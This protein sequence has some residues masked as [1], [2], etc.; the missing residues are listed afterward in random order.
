MLS[1][2]LIPLILAASSAF[3]T[4]GE[5]PRISIPS[6]KSGPPSATS[7]GRSSPAAWTGRR[8]TTN[9]GPGWRKPRATTRRVAV[10]Q[11]MLG[12]LKQSHFAIIPG[13]VYSVLDDDGEGP[14][15]VHGIDARVLDGH[16]VV[17]SVDP[18]SPAAKQGVRPGWQIER[19]GGRDLKTIIDQARSNPAVHE[20]QLTR[21]VLARLSGP[22]GGT[23]DAAVSG[24]VGQDRHP[25]PGPDSAARHA[26]GLR[27]SAGAARLVRKQARLVRR[28]TSASTCFWIFRV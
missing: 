18:G 4:G 20:L 22:I 9:T 19:A 24:R 16:A 6:R 7:T 27:E 21:A 3:G 5:P 15:H 1:R 11:E 14:G 23:L 8:S 25:D 2:R 17:T 12:R 10:M 26:L 13:V 28:P